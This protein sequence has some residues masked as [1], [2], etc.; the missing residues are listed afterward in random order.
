MHPG[1]SRVA[2]PVLLALGIG[3]LIVAAAGLYVYFTRAGD[4]SPSFVKLLQL[5]L[6][7]RPLV[8]ED[9]TELDL[10]LDSGLPSQKQF[11]DAR[12]KRSLTL[13][14][15]GRFIALLGGVRYPESLKNHP[16]GESRTVWVVTTNLGRYFLYFEI[17]QP[18]PGADEGPWVMVE[19]GSL[20][21][22]RSANR[23]ACFELA[24][25]DAVEM[26]D[27]LTRKESYNGR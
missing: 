2:D 10:S 5:E 11:F 21:D 12:V 6:H 7:K 8:I 18:A 24:D 1:K 9:V 27:L 26:I 17:L 23:M 20:D 25:Q 3:F 13:G 22:P 15:R 4:V 16:R 14:E 19:S